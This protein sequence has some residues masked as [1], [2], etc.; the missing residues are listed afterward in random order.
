MH[1]AGSDTA[2]SLE[3]GERWIPSSW[4]AGNGAGDL[5]QQQ[6]ARLP[7]VKLWTHPQCGEDKYSLWD[8]RLGLLTVTAKGKLQ[9]DG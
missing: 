7:P 9:E 6:G 8:G 5:A 1:R 4:I 2:H 3:R